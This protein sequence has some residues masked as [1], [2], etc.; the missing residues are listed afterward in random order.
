[1]S[2]LSVLSW[3][4]L[5]YQVLSPDVIGIKSYLIHI[6]DSLDWPVEDEMEYEAEANQNWGLTWSIT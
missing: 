3:S 6:E 2:S 1:M 4:G 5:N